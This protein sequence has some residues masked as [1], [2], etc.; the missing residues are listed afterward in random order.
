MKNFILNRMKLDVSP[1]LF[2]GVVFLLV[3]IIALMAL[4]NINAR[5][6]SSLEEMLTKGV[7]IM[8]SVEAGT[9]SSMYA[10]PWGNTQLQRLLEESALMPEVLEICITDASGFILSSSNAQRIGQV[11]NRPQIPNLPPPGKW[12]KDD[13]MWEILSPQGDQDIRQQRIMHIFGRFEAVPKKIPLP[14]KND[15][16]PA[17][18]PAPHPGY[19]TYHRNM[20][21][22]VR[23]I[24]VY[25]SMDSMDTRARNMAMNMIVSSFIIFG[26]GL[27]CFIIMLVFQNYRSAKA[28]L[29]KIQ[30]FTDNVINHMPIGLVAFDNNGTV[31]NFNHAAEEILQMKANETLGRNAK[32]VL[33]EAFLSNPA[34]KGK[35]YE[36]ECEL[37]NNKTIFLEI[38]KSALLDENHDAKGVMVLFRDLTE[39]KTLQREIMLN[40][41]MA[42]IGR[43]AAGIAHEIRNPLSSIKGFASYFKNRY[44]DVENDV[45]IAEIMISETERLNRVITQLLEFARPIHVRWTD[46]DMFDMIKDSLTLIAE[47]AKERN[48]ELFFET[49]EHL[50]KLKT[51][52][53]RVRQVLLNLYLNSIDAMPTGGSLT[54]STVFNADKETLG[55]TITDTGCG[56]TPANL[57]KIF[58]PYFTTK[59]NGTGLGL[60]IVANTIEALQGRIKVESST[61]GTTF[62]LHLP[63]KPVLGI[64]IYEDDANE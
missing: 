26:G 10:M 31:V 18:K 48:I 1:W 59:P 13:I 49:P 56:I 39:I 27:A 40:Q 46:V 20:P 52:P 9:R 8:R 51:D 63:L 62:T 17:G 42:S 37:K 19:N 16:P 60:G 41:H 32:T 4:Q 30:L 14:Q 23:L 53:D 38:T 11:M 25:L 50:P 34:T 15:L 45:K 36:A 2:L 43:F 35:S 3:L 47:P 12:S 21:Q 44:K 28:S 24:H 29:R 5:R 6:Q 61:A 64:N 54:V 58:D 22:D 55:I 33:P 57:E 7:A